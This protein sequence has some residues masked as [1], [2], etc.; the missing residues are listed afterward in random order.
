MFRF[1]V[2]DSTMSLTLESKTLD[3]S[4]DSDLS[5]YKLLCSVSNIFIQPVPFTLDSVAETVHSLFSEDTPVVL[6]LAPSD[7]VLY[8]WTKF[9]I[10]NRVG[11]LLLNVDMNV[12]AHNGLVQYQADVSF[13]SPA[14]VVH[15]GQG[16][17]RV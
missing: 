14:E 8:S 7:E 2:F 13:S 6:Q 4:N 11:S 12:K 15:A 16:Q 3:C 17:C 9:Y 10:E 5:L 1:I